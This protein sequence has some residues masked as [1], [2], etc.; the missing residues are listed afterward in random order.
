VIHYNLPKS[1]ENYAQEIGRSGRDGSRSRCTLLAAPSDL[2]PLQNFIYGDTPDPESLRKLIEELP[3]DE[4]ALS[5][6]HYSRRYDIRIVV[7]ET[8]FSYLELEG[9]LQST[10]AFYTDYQIAWNRPQAEVL[11]RFDARRAHFL[12]QLFEQGRR[13]FQW[14]H[15]HMEGVLRNLDQPRQRIVVRC[16]YPVGIRI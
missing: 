1:L 5:L 13:C 2:I 14:T 15:L 11:A 9:K 3:P 12:C 7:L 16:A 10:G 6:F 4:F 8:A